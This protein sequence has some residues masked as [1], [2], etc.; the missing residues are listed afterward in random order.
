M[1]VCKVRKMTNSA[2]SDAK[3]MIFRAR[4]A[5]MI[6]DYVVR[7]LRAR[8]CRG[9]FGPLNCPAGANRTALKETFMA[10]QNL[11][12][13]DFFAKEDAIADLALLACPGAEDSPN[14]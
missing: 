1:P 9:A 5:K 14:W 12:P 13:R 11:G 6:L 4:C 2:Q 8:A 3:I 10:E 7:S